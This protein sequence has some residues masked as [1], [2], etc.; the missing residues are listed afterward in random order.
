MAIT[1]LPTVCTL[2]RF[3]RLQ[4]PHAR[5]ADAGLAQWQGRP[6][7]FGSRATSGLTTA[8]GR[9]ACAMRRS[10]ATCAT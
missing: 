6:I 8:S 2:A 1:P 9:I 7:P 5:A 10:N 3:R 4:P